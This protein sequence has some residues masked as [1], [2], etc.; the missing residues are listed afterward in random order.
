MKSPE[1]WPPVF[2]IMSARLEALQATLTETA[3]E[4]ERVRRMLELLCNQF[5]RVWTSTRGQ[6][7]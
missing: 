6:Q 3:L 5:E 7:R 2:N 4:V 1:L